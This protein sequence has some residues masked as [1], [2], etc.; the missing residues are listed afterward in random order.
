MRVHLLQPISSLF[1]WSSLFAIFCAFIQIKNTVS[2]SNRPF[3][4]VYLRVEPVD[5]FCGALRCNISYAILLTNMQNKFDLHSLMLQDG[6]MPRRSNG[7]DGQSAG[8]FFEDNTVVRLSD[9]LRSKREK[10]YL[11]LMFFDLPDDIQDYLVVEVTNVI[12]KGRRVKT[13]FSTDTVRI[14][15]QVY[16]RNEAAV[17]HSAAINEHQQRHIAVAG[18]EQQQQPSSAQLSPTALSSNSSSTGM[19]NDRNTQQQQ[20]LIEKMHS[21]PP[22]A[23]G[24]TAAGN[25]CTTRSDAKSCECCK[26]VTA[27]KIHLDDEV[28]V[29]VTY[30]PT[31]IGVRVAVLVDGHVYYSKDLALLNPESACFEVPELRD[32][33][34]ICIQLYNLELKDNELTGCTKMEAI[35]L[36]LRVA[37]YKIG[38]FKIPI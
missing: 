26:H 15:V 32:Y 21:R 23:D 8:V 3:L 11:G 10:I 14:G 5:D 19:N 4:D 16:R 30:I 20:Q 27:R 18:E 22:A 6:H 7:N 24:M 34:S 17:D 13:E 2:R 38:C 29:N 33:A 35:L 12:R 1:C 25:P 31:K 36:H 28:C 37:Q 9:E